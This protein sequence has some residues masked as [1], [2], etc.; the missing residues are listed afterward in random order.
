MIF[1][2]TFLSLFDLEGQLCDCMY[3]FDCF[4]ASVVTLGMLNEWFRCGWWTDNFVQI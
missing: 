4:C 3:G 2:V 1:L